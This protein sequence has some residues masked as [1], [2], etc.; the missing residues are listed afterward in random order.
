ML[1]NRRSI[2]ADLKNPD[3]RDLVLRLIEQADVLIEGFRPGVAERLGVGPE[4]C[5]ET[6][7]RLIYARMTGWG[8]DGKMALRSGHDINCISLTG[9]LHAI[10]RR[11]CAQCR[12]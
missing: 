3:E 1:R 7:P 8:Q 10:G 12:P 2:A 11:G 4:Q 9:A 6:N 5:A